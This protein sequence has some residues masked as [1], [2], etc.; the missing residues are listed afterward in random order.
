MKKMIN[1]LLP[2]TVLTML[3]G[4]S[5]TKKGNEEI[6]DGQNRTV[7][8][9][10]NNIDRVICLG[11]G[12]LRY[13]S[14]I[15]GNEN[16]VAVEEIEKNPFGVGT[17]IRPY[18]LANEDFYK[19]M[20]KTCGKGGPQ[21]QKSGPD[22]E[23]ILSC[24]P[25]IVVSFL[26]SSVNDEITARTNIPVIGLTQGKDGVFDEVTLNSLKVIA[27][28]F[29]KTSRFNELK[30]YIESSKNILNELE[31]SE[32][33]YY[34]GCIGNW[35]STNLFGSY[36]NFPVFKYAKVKNAVD[37]LSDLV[38][39]KQ[40]EIDIEKLTS[41]NPDKI[42]IDGSGYKSFIEDYKADNSKYLGLS[43]LKNKQTY[44]LLPYNA[45]YTN[46]EIQLMSTYYVASVAHP[47]EFALTNIKDMCNEISMKFNGAAIYDKML[48][49]DT[50]LGGYRQ[51]DI[52]QL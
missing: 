13:Y 11:A 21:A 48:E 35:G 18:H 25:N 15:C 52:D 43:A 14:Y 33:K 40:V 46:L 42:F 37:D 30:S 6:V 5:T 12:A 47:N 29:N 17:A 49:N 28:V 8:I 24:N 20:E 3:S 26:S 45:Y 39:D 2:L 50:S 27:D 22:Y 51:I 1:L 44:A 31:E 19:S 16:I 38:S 36:T 4:C 10:K 32:E 7:S 9:D 23:A 34:I 41:I